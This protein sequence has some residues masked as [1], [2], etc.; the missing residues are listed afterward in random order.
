MENVI[1]I[2]LQPSLKLKKEIFGLIKDFSKKYKVY[3]DLKSYK[4]PRIT[5]LE[6]HSGKYDLNGVMNTIKSISIKFKPFNLGINGIGYF[7]KLDESGKRNFVIYLKVEKNKELFALKKLVDGEFPNE[8]AR[9][10]DRGFVPHITI[11]HRELEKESFYRALK[12]YKNLDFVRTFVVD[13]IMVS[14]RN[15]KTKKVTIKHITFRKK[16]N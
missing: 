13:K 5:I 8:S 4:G 14:K 6:I 11:T 15:T 10:E 7:R 2:W 3:S 12:A 9:H 16:H 1:S